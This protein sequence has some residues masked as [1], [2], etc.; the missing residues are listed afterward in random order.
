M[1]P[2]LFAI[3]CLSEEK[4]HLEW[5]LKGAELIIDHFAK[6]RKEWRIIYGRPKKVDFYEADPKCYILAELS[7]S[8]QT[9]WRRRRFY[10]TFWNGSQASSSIVW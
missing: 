10:F 4:K 8:Y 7:L 6:N 5:W 1:F 2:L 3:V 9:L